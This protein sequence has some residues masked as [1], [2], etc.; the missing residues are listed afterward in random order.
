[1]RAL[2]YKG[3]ENVVV[4]TFPDPEVGPRDALLTIEACGV[5]GSDVSSYLHGHY[6]SEGQTLGQ[7]MSAVV[8][9]IGAE[10]A[11]A[12]PVGTR[13]AVRPA[14]SCGVCPYCL[15]GV[16][17][18]C[19]DSGARTLGYG[20]PGGFADVVLYANVT[21]GADL[22]AIPAE[23]SADEVLWAEPLAVAVR[24]VRRAGAVDSVL[25]L[26]GGSVGLCVAA[27]AKAAGIARVTVS[28][29][30]DERRAA[31]AQIGVNVAKPGDKVELVDAVIDT[32]GVAAAIE[33][34]DVA[35]RPGGI[36]VTVGLG[37][38]PVPW[39]VHDV[40]A[41]FAYSDDDFALA[42]DHIVSGRVRLGAFV[43]HRSGLNGAGDAIRASANDPSVVKAAIVPSLD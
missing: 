11:Q 28:E 27:A 16:P 32:S 29:P 4:E 34:A 43:T 23:V 39:P 15:D 37:D 24:A 36:F 13:V 41:S 33:A 40:V 6:V 12:L 7:E 17:G 20:V 3:P 10:L 21:V 19:G 9:E 5:C 31:A 35:L 2:V 25:V 14:R 1:M 18:L 26:G 8:K 42:V 38:R 22:Y 30:R